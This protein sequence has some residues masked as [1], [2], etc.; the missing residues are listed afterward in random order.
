MNESEAALLRSSL[1]ELKLRF[2]DANV[3]GSPRKAWLFHI[4][5]KGDKRPPILAV[6]LDGYQDYVYLRLKP[7]IGDAVRL[8]EGLPAAFQTRLW[9]RP[10]SDI[11]VRLM[12]DADRIPQWVMAVFELLNKSGVGP[13]LRRVRDLPLAER[14][15]GFKLGAD[16]ELYATLPDF[17]AASVEAISIIQNWLPDVSKRELE[18]DGV[19]RILAAVE[20]LR[21]DTPPIEAEAAVQGDKA[22]ELSKAKGRTTN[23]LRPCDK[24]AFSQYQHAIEQ[25]P[26]IES[27]DEAY[28]WLVEDLRADGISLTRRD[29]WKRYVGRA[30]THYGKQKN[31]PRIGNETHSVVSATRI[32]A[33]KRTKA[34]QH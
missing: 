22:S 12:S 24:K 19:A 6:L 32:D 20:Q 10:I 26:S 23:G 15:V 33:P 5:D 11:R 16:A 3:P 34:D 25:D 30:R 29:N 8:L 7:I 17:A 21:T 13:P 1:D 14:P 9:G 27:D 2:R 28:D 31:G 18:V 4:P